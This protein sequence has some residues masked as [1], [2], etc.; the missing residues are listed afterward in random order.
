LNHSPACCVLQAN[1]NLHQLCEDISIRVS[2]L[3]MRVYSV[4]YGFSQRFSVSA[5]KAYDWCTDYRPYD[6][7]LMKIKGERSIHKITDDTIVLNETTYS[8]ER[9][10]KKTKLVRL[11]KS[12]LSWSSTHVSGPYRHSQFLYQVVPVGKKSSKLNFTGLL[13]CYS[14][15]NLSPTKIKQ[16]A[17]DER[18]QD[19]RSWRHLAN[20]MAE[21]FQ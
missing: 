7:S 16:I 9:T 19:S 13:L 4:K 17:K 10:V 8:K 11:D 3:R 15:T 2:D 18:R 20:A 6:L 14:T 12:H 5:R 21:N 1:D